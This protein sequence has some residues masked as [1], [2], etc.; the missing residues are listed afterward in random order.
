MALGAFRSG[1]RFCDD[2][3][4]FVVVGRSPVVLDGFHFCFAERAGRVLLEPLHQADEVEAEVVAGGCYGA[5]VDCFEADGAGFGFGWG[6][7]LLLALQG[8]G[9]G[10]FD[11]EIIWRCW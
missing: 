9:G 8:G 2:G 7:V 11:L 10:A 3:V 5:L 6:V 4:C 1:V